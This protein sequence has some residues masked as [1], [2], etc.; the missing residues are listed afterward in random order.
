MVVRS[1]TVVDE[2]T[3]A[4]AIRHPQMLMRSTDNIVFVYVS[5]EAIHKIVSLRIDRIFNVI[6]LCTTTTRV[7][8]KAFPHASRIYVAIKH[9]LMHMRH[10]GSRFTSAVRTPEK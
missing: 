2:V 3:L 10:V 5:T 6:V 9:Q 1:S 7:L 4:T 8:I